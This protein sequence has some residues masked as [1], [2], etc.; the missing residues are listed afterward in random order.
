MNHARRSVLA[1][2]TLTAALWSAAPLA[3]Q[4]GG[5]AGQPQMSAEEKAMMEAWMK[6]MTPGPQHQHLAAHTGTWSGT[7]KLWQAPGAPPEISQAS[8]ERTL[9]LGGRVL[10]DHWTGNMMGMP[11]EGI[12]VTGYDLYKKQLISTWMDNMGT[13]IMISTGSMNADGS[14]CTMTASFE[15]PATKTTKHLK[16]VTRWTGADTFVF[17]MYD[18]MPGQPD[19]K[20]MEITHARVK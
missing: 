6:A 9:G 18:V 17:E 7:V 20:G 15:D 10:I 16:Q 3:A 4:T 14:E 5:E 13:M 2:L 11:F 8:S 1:C 12:S 19:K